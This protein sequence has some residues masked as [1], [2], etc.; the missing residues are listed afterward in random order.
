MCVCFVFF[1]F[2]CVLRSCDLGF[3]VNCWWWVG[4]SGGCDC[5]GVGVIVVFVD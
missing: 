2:G 5:V 1:C 4:W 3:C